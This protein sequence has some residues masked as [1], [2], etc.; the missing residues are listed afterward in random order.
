M[1]QFD[2]G[3]TDSGDEQPDSL[4][5]S[6][7][8]GPDYPDAICE[9]G[10]Y[11]HPNNRIWINMLDRVTPQQRPF[12]VTVSTNT[13]F[14]LEDGTWTIDF[15]YPDLSEMGVSLPAVGQEVLLTGIICTRGF[16][17]A[18]VKSR[19]GELLW[20]GGNSGCPCVG[21][22]SEELR[23]VCNDGKRIRLASDLADTSSPE[24]RLPQDRD[25]KCQDIWDVYDILVQSDYG[26]ISLK[27]G[28][29]MD[30]VING[31]RFRAINFSSGFL[32]CPCA[33][34]C[35]GPRSSAVVLPVS[36]DK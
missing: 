8:A 18:V 26:D 10:T 30:I 33:T 13:G 1:T 32:H 15:S 2:V 23:D 17:Y 21:T 31:K 29:S 35:S 14:S 6:N 24:C 4:D 28:E 16:P 25:P 36:D 12:V 27:Q 11:T 7:E 19:D 5:D 9:E 20:D 34:D 22:I 3:T